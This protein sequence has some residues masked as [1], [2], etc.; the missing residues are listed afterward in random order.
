MKLEPGWWYVKTE[1]VPFF[2]IVRLVES[3]SEL[4]VD[5]ST[6]SDPLLFA[7]VKD[8]EFIKPVPGPFG[9]GDYQYAC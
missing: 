2:K 6:A 7:E 8:Y 9:N 1:N 3:D 4:F 5:D